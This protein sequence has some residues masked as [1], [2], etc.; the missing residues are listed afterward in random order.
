MP[1]D[2]QPARGKTSGDAECSAGDIRHQRTPEPRNPGTTMARAKWI[3]HIALAT[4]SGTDNSRKS[5]PSLAKWS[6]QL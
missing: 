4:R 3:D 5:G 6:G 2:H 1:T